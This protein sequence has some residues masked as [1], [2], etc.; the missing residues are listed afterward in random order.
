VP[1]CCDRVVELVRLIRPDRWPFDRHDTPCGPK[2][3]ARQRLSARVGGLA[4][5]LAVVVLAA[6]QAGS[7]AAS[8]PGASSD[9][10]A[11]GLAAALDLPSPVPYN[12]KVQ[13]GVRNGKLR[14]V[15][16]RQTSGAVLPGAVSASG[17]SWRST[18][19]PKPGGRYQVTASASQSNGNG[20][21]LHGSFLVAAVPSGRRLT[22]ILTPGNGDVVGVGQPIVIRFDQTVT[23]RKAVE[24]ALIVT[25]SEPVVGAWHW[26]GPREVHFRPTTYW[27]AQATVDAKLSL[28]GVRAGPGLWGARDY[29][30]RFTIGDKHVTVV[31]ARADTLTVRD[32][33]R[34]VKRWPTSLGQPQFATRNGTYVVLSRTPRIHMTSC[35][36][37][38]QCT[39]G[40]PNYYALWV[41]WDVRLT[42]SGTFVHAAPWSVASQGRANVSHG[43]SNL[44]TLH[45]E[46]YYKFSRPGDVVTVIHSAR[47]DRDLVASGD[48]GMADWNWTPAQWLA[49]SAL[50][51]WITTQGLA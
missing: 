31:Y 35:S 46:W 17:T 39:K 41:K 43:C 26:V 19:R 23:D 30:T 1:R 12:A 15:T 38:I 45:G 4:A 32:Q 29:E 50:G 28:N 27:P 47:N 48:P 7:G 8:H 44:S 11:A 13:I 18:G 37:K 42:N 10:T 24:R 51:T 9:I 16:V 49:G 21:T 5:G 33:G 34:M 20:T 25:T 22:L 14:T 36:A 6:C 3:P 40:A 2:A